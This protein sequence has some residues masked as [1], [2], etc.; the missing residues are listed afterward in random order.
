[1]HRSWTENNGNSFLQKTLGHAML[2]RWGMIYMRVIGKYMML[3][4][5]L[6]AV[7]MVGIGRAECAADHGDDS[8]VT[9]NQGGE[10]VQQRFF[11][12]V[13]FGSSPVPHRPSAPIK[14]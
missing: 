4:A 12:D 3:A 6:A 2:Y 10:T 13:D 14:D 7:T 11:G 9:A 8:A 1:M 5:V